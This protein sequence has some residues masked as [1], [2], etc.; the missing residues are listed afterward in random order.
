MKS[1]TSWIL[2]LGAFGHIYGTTSMFSSLSS[3]KFPHFITL[4]NEPEVWP[5]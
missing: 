1:Q 3:S 2:D 4:A 5:E